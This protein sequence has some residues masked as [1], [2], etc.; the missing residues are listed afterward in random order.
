MIN[1]HK[2]IF[3]SKLL[4][5]E[6]VLLWENLTRQEVAEDS[7]YLISGLHGTWQGKENKHIIPF[8]ACGW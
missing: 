4:N 3:N 6:Q 8:L 5:G 2:G 1:T 7:W